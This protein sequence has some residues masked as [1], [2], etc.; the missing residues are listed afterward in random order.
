[1]AFLLNVD[2]DFV[3][4]VLGPR[5]GA[6]DA[7]GAALRAVM[8]T[9]GSVTP[10]LTQVLGQA[11]MT[12]VVESDLSGHSSAVFA[13]KILRPA[14]ADIRGDG[15]LHWG[16]TASDVAQ[17]LRDAPQAIRSG[18]LEAMVHW[19][20]NGKESAAE[21][22]KLTIGPLLVAVWPKER[23]FRDV[24]L[25]N[26]WIELTVGAGDEFPSA[27][28]QLQPFIVPFDRGLGSLLAIVNRPGFPGGSIP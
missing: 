28:E 10:E 13:S 24:S 16:V 22:W 4:D 3:I 19:L 15:S 11:I 12:G 7:E 6:P 8:L 20:R 5:I 9:Y 1:M 14:L 21:I 23:E 2:R 18:T 27:L 25:T 17:T 26:H